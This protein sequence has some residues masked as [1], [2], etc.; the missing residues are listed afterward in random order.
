MSHPR[1]EP[2]DYDQ[3][4]GEDIYRQEE[5]PCIN[6][7]ADVSTARIPTRAV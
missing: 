5:P 2:G 3:Q 1:I 4:R 7:S 6:G